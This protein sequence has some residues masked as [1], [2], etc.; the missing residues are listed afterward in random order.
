MQYGYER[1][2]GGSSLAASDS[3]NGLVCIVSQFMPANGLAS[4]IQTS[5]ARPFTDLLSS[6]QSI[7]LFYAAISWFGLFVSFYSPPLVGSHGK[8]DQ[9]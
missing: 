1:L 8:E 5:S 2:E 7:S 3:E 9:M 6:L 4:L